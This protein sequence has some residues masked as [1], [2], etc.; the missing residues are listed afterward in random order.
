[1]AE[2]HSLYC[3]PIPVTERPEVPEVVERVEL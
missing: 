1:L 3:H 2:D